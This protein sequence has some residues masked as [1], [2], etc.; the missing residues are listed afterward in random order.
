MASFP[1]IKNKRVI[2]TGGASGIGLAIAR[3]FGREGARLFLLDISADKLQEASSE[4]SADS[5]EVVTYKASVTDTDALR[6]AFLNCDKDFGSVDILINNAGI[7]GHIRTLDIRDE[8]WQ[9][10]LDI[11]LTGL[12][13]CAREA[14]KRMCSQ[15][16]GVIINTSSIYG[17]AAAP[18]RLG[19]CVTKSGAV[20]L[21]KTLAIEWA[22]YGV[23][24]NA[25]APGYIKTDLVEN[26]VA[27]GAYDLDS[28]EK[29]T[30]MG[31]LGT[32]QEVA[33]A[34][35][36]LASDRARFITGQVLGIDGGWSSYGYL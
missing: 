13:K 23:R 29:R 3:E 5:I 18:E 2:V 8:Q 11:N 15:G 1:D 10:I 9:R 17:I 33:D 16:S 20:M 12:F 28:I 34:A 22:E 30:P 19:Y 4:L 36:F 27:S 24:V 14:G 35:V 21:T 7:S 32:P 25:L 31:R 6:K 26:L